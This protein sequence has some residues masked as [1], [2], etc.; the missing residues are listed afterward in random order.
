VRDHVSGPFAAINADDWYPSDG[1]V[2]LAQSLA[3]DAPAH[4]AL[5]T[6]RLDTT[7]LSTSGGVSRA[8]CDVRPDGTLQSMFEVRDIEPSGRGFIGRTVDGQPVALSGSEAVSMN[9]WGFT[10]AIFDPLATQ[11]AEFQR[12]NPLDTDREFLIGT[13]VDEQVRTGRSTVRVL[14]GGTA[15]FGMTYRAD[16]SEV[17]GRIRALIAEGRY[18]DRLRDGIR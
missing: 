4:H 3:V 13:A 14:D 16:L 2:R 11:F 17:A 6:Y 5:V 8:V 10:P 7:P 18:P 12:A 9:L 1:Y 15:G